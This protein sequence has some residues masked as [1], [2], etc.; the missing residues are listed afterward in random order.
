MPTKSV[1]CEM[2]SPVVDLS[3][4]V[5]IDKFR[6]PSCERCAGNR[7][8]EFSLESGSAI[9]SATDGIVSFSGE[10]GR[11]KYLVIKTRNNR[12][13]TY[14]RIL[15]SSVRTGDV[16]V[17]GQQIATSSALLYF[18][19]REIYGDAVIYVDPMRYLTSRL[20]TGRAG[21]QFVLVSDSNN[22]YLMNAEC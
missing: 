8:V 6:A 2:R 21:R 11:V 1:G 7:G 14:G 17:V 3:K 16:V 13:I 5:V 12:R 22:E 4:V 10:V 9:F 19:I 20:N 15:T 18:G